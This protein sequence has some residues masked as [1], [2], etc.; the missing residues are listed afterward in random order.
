MKTFI[1]ITVACCF[2]LPL[3]SQTLLKPQSLQH[4]YY[5]GDSINFSNNAIW[6]SNKQSKFMLGWQ[7]AGPNKATNERLHINFQEQWFNA[8]WYWSMFANA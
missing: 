5:S 3:K 8:G 4:L 2:I 1:L 7:W 6:S